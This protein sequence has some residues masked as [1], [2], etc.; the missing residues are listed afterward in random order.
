M[1]LIVGAGN[2]AQEYARV[3]SELEQKFVVVGRGISS[4]KRF[5]E[6]TGIEVKTGGLEEYCKTQQLEY[7]EF[8]FV[9]TGMEE[10]ASTTRTLIDRGVRKILVE[11]PAGIDLSEV[12]ELYKYASAL[13]AKIYVAYNRRFY[14]SVQKAQE[15]ISMDGGVKNFNFEIT[16]W[17]HV[18]EALEKPDKVKQ[19]WFLANTSHVIDLAFYLGGIPESL[20]SFYSGSTAWH[21]RS[22]AYSGAGISSTGALF[23]YF[24]NWGAPGRWSVEVL[25]PKNRLI[26][27]PLEKLMIQKIGS[28]DKEYVDLSDELDKEFKPGI[29]L[30]VK[31]FLDNNDRELCTLQE[32]TL[33]S[34]Y[35]AKMAG[36]SHA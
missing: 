35:Y 14:S 26:L 27:C 19:N 6:S 20:E 11:K 34:Q 17:G 15:I 9:T 24:G 8:A 36:Y 16:E 13:N 2:M 3:L 32:H 12:E 4:A 10:L 33:K 25:T 23:S 31:A 28:I 1:I 21:E 5:Q 7:I 30:Q 29:Y 22:Y 18:I